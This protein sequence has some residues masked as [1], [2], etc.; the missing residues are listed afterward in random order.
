MSE[1]QQ[2]DRPN[3][4]FIMTDQESCSLSGCYG[5]AKI[6]T[7]ARDSIARNGMRF[8]NHYI[9][10][11]PCSPSRATMITGLYAHNHGVVTN[12]VVL[13]ERIETLGSQLGQ[14][15]YRTTWIG[16]SHMAGW[17][18]PH[19]EPTC[20]YHEL[21][22]TEMGYAWKKYPGGAG[23]EDYRLNGF[24][25]WISGWTHYRT[26]LQ[27]TDLPQE[28]KNDRWVGGHAVMQT[29]PDGEH[30]YSQLTEDHHMANWMSSEAIKMIERH[31][32][33]ADP[34]CM[35]LSYYAPHHPIAPPKPYDT[36]YDPDEMVLPE[37]YLATHD[38][39]N[40]PGINPETSHS[41]YIADTWTDDQA[42]AYLARYYGYVTY[43]DDQM[44]RVLEALKEQGLHDNTIVVFSSDHGDMLCEQGM[45]YK[46]CYN[47][48][49]T[50]MKVP[51]LVQWPRG[52][53][54][55]SVHDGLSSHVDLT[56]TLLELAGVAQTVPMDG[57]SMAK[58]LTRAG[59]CAGRPAP[60]DEIFVDVHN[61]GFMTRKEEW[62]FV[63][64]AALAGGKAVRKLD[65]L[66][67]MSNDP[68]EMKNLAAEP[69]HAARVETMKQSILTWLEESGYPFTQ[70]IREAAALPAEASV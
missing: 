44:M 66:Y 14:A 60:R 2:K 11:F 16:K 21:E 65:E 59:V 33:L 7:P 40:L 70:Q 46:H 24:Q 28:V 36:M 53:Q 22:E 55:G 8:D 51:M 61:N 17:F 32:E 35:V 15:G 12:G 19:D 45:I 52:I 62:K 25:T 4:L 20:P 23:G 39:K 41:N 42:R 1:L 9:A 37:S 54:A 69:E 5:N 31:K 64:N 63:L 47:G 50:L 34:F 18:E 13:D 49:D 30:A 58:S 6:K 29:A 67:N 3:I 26:Y 68:G 27:G 38:K 48:Y 43:L 56:P 57:R 10:S